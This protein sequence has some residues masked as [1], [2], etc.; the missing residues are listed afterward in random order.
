MNS[1][2]QVLVLAGGRGTR[3]R[4]M[5]NHTPKVMVEIKGTPFLEVLLKNLKKK[6]FTEIVLCVGY[7]SNV[8]KD[9]FKKGEELG[10]KI[11]YSDEEIPLGTGGAIK[12]AEH[13]LEKEFIVI[14]GDTF[15]DLDLKKMIEFSQKKGKLCTISAY[16][17]NDKE[18]DFFNN[19][20]LDENFNVIEYSKTKK[21]SAMNYVDVGVYYFRKDVFEKIEK[22]NPYSVE[23]DV[24]PKLIKDKQIAGFPI[25][26]KFYD[27]GTIKRVD[28]FSQKIYNLE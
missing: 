1:S 7:L 28:K 13:L 10:I 23:F 12:N 3:L 17:G 18:S 8:I 11:T 22:K 26:K 4:P 14:N 2:M 5:T 16:K 20:L 19:L 25:D 9:Y 27:I 24:F 6:G 15:V 21:L